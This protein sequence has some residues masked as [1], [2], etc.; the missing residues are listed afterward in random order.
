M[1]NFTKAIDKLLKVEGGYSFRKAD[2]GGETNWGITKDTAREHGYTGDMREMDLTTA[3]GIYF[4]GWWDKMG[5]DAVND[6]DIAEEIFD[7]AVNCGCSFAIRTL[8]RSLNVLNRYEQDWKDIN[9]D[10]KIGPVTIETLNEA[11]KK[12]KD[13]ILKVLNVLQAMKYIE[14]AERSDRMDEL[15]INGWIGHRIRIGEEGK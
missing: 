10:G 13:N 11:S 14:L 5:L 2:A 15:N 7:T 6:Q 12:R 8:Q 1:A 3:K 4:I 9:A